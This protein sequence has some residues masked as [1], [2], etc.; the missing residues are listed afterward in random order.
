[1]QSI[2]ELDLMDLPIEDRAF[3][4]DPEPWFAQARE[5]HPWLARF[6]HGYLVHGHH[7]IRDLMQMDDKLHI[8][9]GDVV[10]IMGATG[11][12]WG[13]FMQALLI[14]RH[15]EDHKRMRDA[16]KPFFKPRRIAGHVELIREVVSDLLDEW[17]PK[18][19]F[20]FTE[21]ASNFPVAV[22]FGLIGA[23]I[24]DL[25]K[26]KWALEV[27]GLSYS[28]DPSLLPE[29][30]KAHA[31]M[32]EF[33]SDLVT[34]RRASGESRDDLLHELVK[35]EDAGVLSHQEVCEQL[36]FLF[37]AGYDTSK[38]QLGMTARL[39]FQQPELWQRCAHDR[40]FCTLA[41]E[42]GLRHSS[43]SS[44]PRIAQE[45]IEYAGVLIPKGTH[46]MFLLNISGRD[47]RAF[48][49]P[50]A[51][52]PGR[53]SAK[54]HLAFGKGA[55]ICLGLHLARFQMEEGLHLIAQRLKDPEIVGEVSWRR[56]PGVWGLETLPIRFTPAP[57]AQA[58]RARAETC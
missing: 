28:L 2:A 22:M 30:E 3:G 24:A 4:A 44:P 12:P 52:R 54:H 5:R 48:E 7:E 32:M 35:A 56:F 19:E 46:L 20:D 53:E 42:E 27:Q 29:M 9:T 1:M 18:G 10:E 6:T 23:D 36:F 25:P 15:G 49:D 16:L 37:A 41:I 58:E 47:P 21:F 50:L 17:A 31:M 38:N 57:A 39:L 34:K 55:H 11:K 26:I 45:D 51:Y 43:P 33:N 40:D 14:S 8:A 13:D